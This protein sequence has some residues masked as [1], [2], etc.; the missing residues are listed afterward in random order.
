MYFRSFTQVQRLGMFEVHCDELIRALSKRAEQI[1][2]KLLARMCKDHQEANK[3]WVHVCLP[4]IFHFWLTT[5]QACTHKKILEQ[6]LRLLS[7]GCMGLP[8]QRFTWKL[9][10][11]VEFQEY[12][13]D[14][15][16]L[17]LV[18]RLLRG[19]RCWVCICICGAMHVFRYY[20][21][22]PY[23]YS[24]NRYINVS[25]NLLCILYTSPVE[26]CI[27]RT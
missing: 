15:L 7:F 3:A 18:S 12:A 20:Y 25:L 24:S 10:L 26:C 11:F 19:V 9:N 17:F 16:V 6:Q 21:Y 23:S 8:S 13:K 22:Y 1:S 14:T 27:G 4:S 2:N 5:N